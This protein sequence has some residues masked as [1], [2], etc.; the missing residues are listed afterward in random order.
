M[1]DV[2]LENGYTRIAN[3]LVRAMAKFSFSGSEFMILLAVISKTY[4]WGKA[5]DQ[6]SISQ[7]MD[8]TGLTR[9]GVCKATSALVNKK[10]LGREQKGTRAREQKGTNNKYY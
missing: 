9:R 5:D 6:I 3:D 1:A 7:L 10:A 8:L 4:G 2:Q